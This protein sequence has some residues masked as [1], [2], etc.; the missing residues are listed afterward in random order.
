MKTFKQYLIEKTFNIG[1]DVDMI[2]KI[3]FKKFTDN[4]QKKSPYIPPLVSQKEISSSMLKSKKAQE[5][6]KLNPITIIGGIDEE[7]K[8]YYEPFHKMIKLSLNISALALLRDNEGVLKDSLEFIDIPQRKNYLTE[9]DG[10]SIKSSIYHELSH[11]INDT[12]HGGHIKKMLAHMETATEKEYYYIIRQGEED[13]AVTSYEL[14]AQ[15]HAIK[16]LKRLN[17]NK[18][19]LYSFGDLLSLNPSLNIIYNKLSSEGRLK[20]KKK[21]LKRMVREKLLG[22]NMKGT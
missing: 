20:W 7:G 16:Q 14:D 12:L 17:K 13:I 19:N 6:H 21:L 8:N 11:W 2:Y 10:S 4:F 1:K 15:I 18:W 22:K 5:A 9:F 3:M